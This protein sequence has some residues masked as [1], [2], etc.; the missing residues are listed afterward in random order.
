MMR[1]CC[2]LDGAPDWAFPKDAHG[3]WTNT[4]IQDYSLDAFVEGAEA[5]R[6]LEIWNL[7]FMQFDRQQDGTM[8][9]LPKPSVDTGAGLERIGDAVGG[10]SQ[11]ASL[12]EM[13]VTSLR[14]IIEGLRAVPIG[15]P[16][17]DGRRKGDGE[18]PRAVVQ[19]A[20]VAAREVQRPRRQP[21]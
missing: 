16:E 2:I 11:P 5:G 6:F 14:G 21:V 18:R 17:L 13:T 19:A 8:V 12:S 1:T 4:D 20:H 7:V 15:P 10:I 3:E 9:P